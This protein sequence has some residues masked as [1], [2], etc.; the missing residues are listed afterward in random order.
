MARV[1]L[2]H[3]P[4]L[5]EKRP[6]TTFVAGPVCQVAGQWTK[7]E[8]QPGDLSSGLR[9][10]LWLLRR[11]HG[12]GVTLQNAY[13]DQVVLNTYSEPGM[14]DIRLDDLKLHSINLPWPRE[15]RPIFTSIAAN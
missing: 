15:P 2:P 10:Q 5:D 9:E 11:Q 13:V 12:P 3:S 7:L 8:F 6:I 14:V 1:V 4:H